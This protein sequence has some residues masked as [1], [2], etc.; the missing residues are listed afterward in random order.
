[1][2]DFASIHP[3]ANVKS[4]RPDC[5]ALW[6]IYLN[7]NKKFSS[8]KKSITYSTRQI[9]LNKDKSLRIVSYNAPHHTLILDAK[10]QAGYSNACGLIAM[11]V[12]LRAK[13]ESHENIPIVKMTE[14]S[15]VE[16]KEF[17]NIALN[18]MRT[19]AEL[20]EAFYQYKVFNNKKDRKVDFKL[21]IMTERQIAT[22]KFGDLLDEKNIIIVHT[23]AA[24][25]GHYEPGIVVHSKSLVDVKTDETFAIKLSKELEEK[26]AQI[27]KDALFARSLINTAPTI[28]KLSN[29]ELLALKLQNEYN[30]FQN[31]HELAL[32]LAR[33]L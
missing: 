22:L 27:L 5:N 9:K 7:D 13:G 3:N 31:D 6:Q 33:E 10:K 15:K 4:I 8:I 2:A 28:K 30:Q 16:S 21:F 18:E 14:L 20:R 1:M 29:D 17:K 26:D 12:A 25:G 11:Y 19:D 23:G 24:F 32:R